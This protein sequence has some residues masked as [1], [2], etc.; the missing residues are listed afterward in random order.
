M[1]S[2]YVVIIIFKNLN[3]FF[4]FSLDH[5]YLFLKIIIFESDKII[6]NANFF[7]VF[8]TTT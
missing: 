6:I 1:S 3:F 2:K 8:N 4:S 5:K 7:Q